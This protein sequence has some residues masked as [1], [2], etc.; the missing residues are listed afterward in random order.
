[1]W[2]CD[3][4]LREGRVDPL[5]VRGRSSTRAEG[6]NR[7]SKRRLPVGVD[8]DPPSRLTHPR[9]FEEKVSTYPIVKPLLKDP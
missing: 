4:E 7:K 6:V 2:N 8:R 3:R 9:G 5:E 1:M